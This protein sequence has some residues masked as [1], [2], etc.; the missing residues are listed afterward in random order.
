M[1]EGLVNFS[2]GLNF[3]IPQ[4]ATVMHDIRGLKRSLSLLPV[5]KA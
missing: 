1:I 4:I 3:L 2:M 5:Q